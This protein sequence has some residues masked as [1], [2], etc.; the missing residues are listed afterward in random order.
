MTLILVLTTCLVSLLC[1]T[2]A[3]F[4]NQL[5]HHPVR[6]DRYHEYYRWLTSGFVHGDFIHLAVN[7]FVLY[8]FGSMVEYSLVIHLGETTGSIVYVV[9]YLLTIVMGDIPTFFRHRHNPYFASVGA[10][11]GV[12]GILFHYILLQPWSMLGLYAIIPVPAIIF[13]VL[14]LWYSTWASKNQH[15]MIDHEA[16]FYGA[17]AGVLVAFISRPSVLPEFLYRLVHDFPF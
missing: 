11:G 5:K 12:S 1:F 13:G 16:H 4:F 10:S 17:I 3:A 7:M 8:Q 15:D 9:G 14:Y 2:N 6:E